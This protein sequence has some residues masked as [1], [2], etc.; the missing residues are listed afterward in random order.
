M[1]WAAAW[2]AGWVGSCGLCENCQEKF[3]ISKRSLCHFGTAEGKVA[4]SRIAVAARK[5]TL[6]FFFMGASEANQF[7]VK[8]EIIY[9]S[10]AS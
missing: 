4:A 10:V 1:D 7:A 2:A 8:L 9:A 6:Q 5:K 3:P